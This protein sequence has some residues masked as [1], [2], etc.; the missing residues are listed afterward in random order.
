MLFFDN[1]FGLFKSYFD[2]KKTI[3]T[4]RAD[5]VEKVFGDVY[6]QDDR[7]DWVVET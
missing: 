3:N 5:G 1:S 7:Q 2:N 4:K 6:E